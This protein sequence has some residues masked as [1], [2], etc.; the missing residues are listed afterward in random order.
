MSNN[1][2]DNGA[3]RKGRPPI[4]KTAMSPARRQRRRRK[5]LAKEKA[6]GLSKILARQKKQEHAAR[7]WRYREVHLADGTLSK[8]PCPETKPLAACRR[9]LD[10]GDVLALIRRL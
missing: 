8:I 3:S 2:R 10:G 6:R 1:I 9:D 4:G 7:Y 5:R